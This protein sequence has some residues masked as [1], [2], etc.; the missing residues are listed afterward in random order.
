MEDQ[1]PRFQMCRWSPLGR[2]PASAASSATSIDLPYGELP[3]AGPP[4]I[5]VLQNCRVLLIRVQM[6]NRP[7]TLGA[8]ATALGALGADINLV[9]IVEK[10]GEIEVE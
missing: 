2:Q 7:G 6:P 4:S 3:G 9:E 10:R 5:P 8:V 1:L